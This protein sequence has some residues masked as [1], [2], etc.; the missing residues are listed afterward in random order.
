[1]SHRLGVLD[2]TVPMEGK[3]TTADASGDGTL[4]Y[5]QVPLGYCWYIERISTHGP[6]SGTTLDVHVSPA[7]DIA[8]DRTRTDYTA[9]GNDAIL[10]EIQPSFVPGGYYLVFKWANATSGDLLVAS[11][12]YAVHELNPSRQLALSESDRRTVEAS[13]EKPTAPVNDSAVAERRA[14]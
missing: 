13:H 2:H 4:Y 12:Q 8:D 9:N 10:D 11:V 5:G 1:M 7:P 3:V 6:T 14:V